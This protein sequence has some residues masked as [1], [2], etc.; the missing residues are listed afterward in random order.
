MKYTITIIFMFLTFLI[1]AQPTM[2]NVSGGK[3][4]IGC[5]NEQNPDCLS[6]EYPVHAISLSDFAIGKYEVTQSEWYDVMGDYPSTNFNSSGDDNKPVETVDWY[7]VI[8]F[9]N[10]QTLVDPSISANERV[11]FR[12]AAFTQP[13][14]IAHY[15][16]NGDTPSGAVYMDLSR[17]GYRLPTE[18][19]WEYAARG[20]ALSNGYKY[21]GS[22]TL[23][24]VGW[25]IG[26]SGNQAHIVG[27][28]TANEL[29]LHDM[30]GNV[31][32]WTWD[33]FSD[34]YYTNQHVCDP[35]GPGSG[36][37][38]VFRGGSFD[39]AAG[40]CRVAYR[41]YYTPSDATYSIGFRLAR[42]L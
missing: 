3:F 8:I 23:G 19:E 17:T 14:E 37:Y 32:E 1:L 10:Q 24:G 34:P 4:V 12:D 15:G 7:S 26:N 42:S 28:K 38:R 16:S 31:W 11:Y 25:Y 27:G 29:G 39:N 30:S 20:G 13:W 40:L 2:I 5:T 21:S 33:W 9:C 18:A 6:R 35:T 22:N 36:S 41:G